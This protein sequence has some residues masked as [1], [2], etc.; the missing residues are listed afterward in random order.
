MPIPLIAEIVPK[1]SGQFA[2]LDDSNIRGGFRVCTLTSDRDNISVDKR[3]EGMLVYVIETGSMFSLESDLITWNPSSATGDISSLVLSAVLAGY[4]L[5]SDGSSLVSSDTILAAFQKLQVQVNNKLR[6]PIINYVTGT[7]VLDNS[8][9]IVIV[10]SP[11]NCTIFL[12]VISGTIAYRVKSIGAGR[13]TLQPNGSDTVENQS[14]FNILT[15][16]AFDLVSYS[17]NWYIL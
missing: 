1:N 4:T 16:N 15:K 9:D 17:N 12:P 2:L 14:S 10:N 7:T 11:T 3:K 8:S 6:K 5:G 13:A